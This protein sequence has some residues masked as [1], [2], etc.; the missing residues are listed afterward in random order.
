MDEEVVIVGDDGIEHAFP[1]GFDPK[2]AAAI[3]REQAAP[4]KVP[5]RDDGMAYLGA[6][7]KNIPGSALNVVRDTV[8]GVGGLMTG[9]ADDPVGTATSIVPG[10]MSHYGSRYGS[11]EARERTVR[12]DPAGM[13]MDML[14]VSGALKA[15]PAV[16]RATLR[17]ARTAAAETAGLAARNPIKVSMGLG[18]FPGILAGSPMAAALGAGYGF[19]RAPILGRRFAALKKQIEG[20]PTRQAAAAKSAKAA[21]TSP[22]AVLA[23]EQ[24]AAASA[25]PAAGARRQIPAMMDPPS[26]AAAPTPSAAR[27]GA[28]APA[29]TG[30]E[31]L[32]REM[33]FRDPEY[34]RTT[35]AV[36][37]DALKPDSLGRARTTLEPG[38]SYLGLGDRMAQLAKDPTPENVAEILRLGKALRQRWQVTRKSPTKGKI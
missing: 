7:V 3:V 1:A 14:P 27:G 5:G 32:A 19:E 13:V 10:I 29:A 34:W 26:G 21:A 17:G 23:A 28:T 12:D 22:D 24:S 8:R 2:R 31:A 6:M 25:T 15:A 4:S 11:P 38:E 33:R 9:L 20:G 30:Q 16:G 36:S 37:I 35:D 18:A